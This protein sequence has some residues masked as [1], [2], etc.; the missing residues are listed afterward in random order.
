MAVTSPFA[1]LQANGKT[2]WDSYRNIGR[3]FITLMKKVGEIDVFSYLDKTPV[4]FWINLQEF[5]FWVM[6]YK[7]NVTY[8]SK[9]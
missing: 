8:G 1:I 3:I 6:K 2:V 9:V 4:K 5:Y 7:T